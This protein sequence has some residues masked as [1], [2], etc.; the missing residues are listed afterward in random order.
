MLRS[1]ASRAVPVDPKKPQ[2]N[3][4]HRQKHRRSRAMFAYPLH[5]VALVLV[6]VMLFG[7]LA[8]C[9]GQAPA[10]PTDGGVAG[11][12]EIHAAE[13][14]YTPNSTSVDKPGRYTIKLV[15]DGKI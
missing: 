3:Q 10:G 9:A 8:A 5:R 7:L 12:V 15:N 13:F 11:V 1:P 4:K 14:A 2:R 6:G